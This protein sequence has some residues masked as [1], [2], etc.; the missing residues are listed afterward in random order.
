MPSSDSI[1][2]FTQHRADIFNRISA[3]LNAGD[4]RSAL[5]TCETALNDAIEDVDLLTVAGVCA[6]QSHAPDAARNYWTRAVTMSDSAFQAAFN[7]GLLCA[8]QQHDEL[9]ITWFAW[10]LE[11]TAEFV[12]ARIEL[13][14]ALARLGQHQSAIEQFEQ[15]L[16]VSPANAQ[17]HAECGVSYASLR[18]WERAKSHY[19]RAL[20]LAPDDA[21]TMSN[22]G[23]VFAAKKAFVDAERWHRN[24]LA[25]QPDN[26]A[27][28]AN[29]ALALEGQHRFEE[30]EAHHLAA[31]A[32][33]PQVAS[34]HSNLA[35]MLT[36]CHRDSEAGKHYEAALQL[37]PGASSTW[38]NLGVLQSRLGNDTEAERCLRKAIELNP[39]YPMAK[40]NLAF[41]LLTQGRLR[42][43]WE[44]HEARYHPDLPDPDA[45]LPILS[46]RQWQGESL[47]GKSL[48]IWP[49]QGLGDMLH[50]CRYVPQL[51]SSGARHVT[52]VCKTPLLRLMRTLQGVDEVLS[53]AEAELCPPTH[54]YWTFPMSLPLHCATGLENIPATLPYLHADAE[55]VQAWGGRF[56]A[57]QPRIALMWRGNPNHSNDIYRS[58]PSF[59][60]LAPLWENKECSFISL[61]KDVSTEVLRSQFPNQAVTALGDQIEDFADTAAI[62]VQ[63]DLLITV[64]TAIAHLAGALNQACCLLLPARQTDWRWMRDREDSPWYPGC[65]KLFRQRANEDWAVTVERLAAALPDLLRTV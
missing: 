4:A 64:D 9:A 43:A 62:L 36:N 23:I 1:D 58:L 16:A 40:L 15:I 44:W 27:T 5:A 42:E 19:E 6:I 30:A 11:R 63:C 48:L 7:L 8:Q 52:L 57:H 47:V 28:L 14:R 59:A 56:P 24:A 45:L 26:Y 22:L 33:A 13:A 61:Q 34:L 49:E 2:S 60:T 53:L 17:I 51:K 3:Y 39:N 50:F 41:L 32:L 18:E 20:I 46:G 55:L 54:D 25:L 12:L 29:L 38:S 65:M 10:I 21:A 31:L 35:N 37:A